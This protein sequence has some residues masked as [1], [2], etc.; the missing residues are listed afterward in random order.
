[1]RIEEHL[2]FSEKCKFNDLDL[3]DKERLITCFEDRIRNFYLTP[4][5]ILNEQ[6]SGFC[7][8]LICIALIDSLARIK[9]AVYIKSRKQEEV[10]KTGHVT[11]IKKISLNSTIQLLQRNFMMTSVVD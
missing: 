11:W 2:Y 3:D 9:H 7:C 4:A 6:K 1:M 5:E 10:K 8:M